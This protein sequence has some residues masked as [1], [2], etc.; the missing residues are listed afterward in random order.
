MENNGPPISTIHT[1]F[2]AFDST[3]NNDVIPD[4][5]SIK[6]SSCTREQLLEMLSILEAEL[7]ARDITVATL[8]VCSFLILFSNLFIAYFDRMRNYVIC[9]TKLN[10]AEIAWT[11]RI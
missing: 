8:Q 11:I 6:L 9:Y 5:P 4:Q 10:M 3:D 1:Q 2:E 7:Q